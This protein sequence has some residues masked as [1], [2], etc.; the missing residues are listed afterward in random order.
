M[1][2]LIQGSLSFEEIL[3]CLEEIYEGGG[4]SS[5]HIA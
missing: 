2:H 3:S 5:E 1:S 4:V